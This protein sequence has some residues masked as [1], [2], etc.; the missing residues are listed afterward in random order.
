MGVTEYDKA[1]PDCVMVS[2]NG[3]KL[4]EH[5][6]A[7]AVDHCARAWARRLRRSGM[8]PDP[9]GCSRLHRLFVQ[10]ERARS[11]RG[12]RQ[13]VHG[14]VACPGIA[15][16]RGFAAPGQTASTCINHLGRR[17]SW[18]GRL[19]MTRR[20]STVTASRKSSSSSRSGTVFPKAS[21]GF[22]LSA[23]TSCAPAVSLN[24]ECTSWHLDHGSGASGSRLGI[25]LKEF[26]QVDR[27][28][29]GVLVADRTRP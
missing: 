24:K 6:D 19:H 4:R 27:H 14:G 2:V 5:R 22:G 7:A 13:R 20:A 9:A 11:A 16:A 10:K 15:F 1:S 26:A 18:R 28:L 8:G 21:C 23:T 17:P 25:S 29:A 12:P 3:P